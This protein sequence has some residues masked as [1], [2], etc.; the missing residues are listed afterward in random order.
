MQR[1]RHHDIKVSF[2]ATTTLAD[3]PA[4]QWRKT[5]LARLFLS[6]KSPPFSSLLQVSSGMTATGGCLLQIGSEILLKELPYSP[7]D[8][9]FSPGAGGWSQM[10]VLSTWAYNRPWCNCTSIWSW[11]RTV[12]ALLSTRRSGSFQTMA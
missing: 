7:V 5:L 1:L 12:D 9:R 10:S 3:P 4:N 2:S 8:R 6:L 11:V